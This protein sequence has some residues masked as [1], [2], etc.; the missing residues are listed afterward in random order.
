MDNQLTTEQTAA[1]EQ[2]EELSRQAEQAPSEDS[3]QPS[4]V[5]KQLSDAA[6]LSVPISVVT[7]RE[8]ALY[9]EAF[10]RGAIWQRVAPAV[11]PQPAKLSTATPAS[12]SKRLAIERLFYDLCDATKRAQTAAALSFAEVLEAVTPFAADVI[13]RNCFSSHDNA[14]HGIAVFSRA[15]RSLVGQAANKQIQST[16]TRQK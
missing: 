12:A 1:I 8:I 5:D 11:H 4:A 14:R 2:P 7:T 10:I 9:R 6:A 16:K 3:E 13:C 15:M